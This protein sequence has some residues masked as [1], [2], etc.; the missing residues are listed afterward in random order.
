MATGAKAQEALR[1]QKDARQKKMLIA[2][3]P[4]LL[5]LLFWQGPGMLKAFSGGSTP[6][7]TPAPAQSSG[8][9]PAPADPTAAAAPSTAAGETPAPAAPTS[10][11]PD[12]DD[13]VVA[14]NDQLVSFDR[15]VGKDPFRQLVEDEE[16]GGG[17]AASDEPADDPSGGSADDPMGDPANGGSGGDGD[18]D[19]GDG[20]GSDGGGSDG[21]TELTI[22]TVDV[23]G[24]REEVSREG[25]FPASDPIF[26]L[27]SL[28]AASAKIALV[29]GEFSNGV[30]TVTLRRGK[31]LTLVSQPDGL[32]YTITLLKTT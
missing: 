3:L 30:E 15:F 19:G 22:A 31:P 21:G 25:T 28:K 20:G 27:V 9:T 6:P 13:P 18:G 1:K 8:E 29:A 11:L 2:L 4:V 24:T 7:P 17:D 26:R 23:N 14:E 32:R 12:T 10:V 16:E 5:L